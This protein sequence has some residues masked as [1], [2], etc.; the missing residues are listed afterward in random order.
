LSVTKTRADTVNFRDVALKSGTALQ[1]TDRGAVVPCIANIERILREDSRWDGVL[2]FNQMAYQVVKR[3]APPYEG[4]AEGP[5]GDV[6]EIRTQIWLSREYGFNALVT[7]VRKAMM[8]VAAFRPFHPVRDYLDALTWDGAPRLLE[9]ACT[10]FGAQD[11]G[12]RGEYSMLA[13]RKWMIAAV[14][15]IYRPGCKADNVLILEGPQG[16]LK[17]SALELLGGEWCMDTPFHIGSKD[18]FLVLQGMWIVELAELDGFTRAESSAAKAFFSSPKDRYVP[19]YVAHA[20]DVPRSCVFAGTVNLGTYLHDRT[21][22]RRYW[23]VQVGDI[24]LEALAR[25]R[26]QLWAEAAALFHDK[27]PHWVT[28]DEVEKFAV[29]QEAREIPDAIEDK[30][31]DYLIG[32]DEVTI[33]AVLE[34]GLK[35]DIKDWSQAMHTR[36]GQ[37]LNRMGWEVC[38]RRRGEGRDR[39]RLYRPKAFGARS[40]LGHPAGEG[41]P[42]KANPDKS[43]S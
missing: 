1:R 37:L 21:G 43:L 36:V 28:P 2:G 31:R 11:A 39:P 32:Q 15:R 38:G 3:K 20:I 34:F 14:A 4:G 42:Q 35:L 12:E 10:H 16:R 6:D 41:G 18:A 40:T 33:G 13:L 19:K 7:D 17:S 30:I 23:P 24:D 22:N 5:W 27:V 25:D 26:D 9:M 8:S 29:E